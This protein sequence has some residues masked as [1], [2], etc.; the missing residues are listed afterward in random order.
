M[1]NNEFTN[2]ERFLMFAQIVFDC[3]LLVDNIF[4]AQTIKQL[5]STSNTL[6][7]IISS[8]LFI[9]SIFINLGYYNRE[10][11]KAQK[12]AKNQLFLT[13]LR[14]IA[15]VF[16]LVFF[17]GHSLISLGLAIPGIVLNIITI[18]EIFNYIKQ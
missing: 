2:K 8:I 4:Y 11:E 18:N 10:P 12:M 15:I 13:V 17:G 14:I 1:S 7:L 6:L 16:F 5:H 9:V 3:I